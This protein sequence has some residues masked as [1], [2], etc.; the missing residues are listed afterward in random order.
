MKYLVMFLMMLAA[1]K[2]YAQAQDVVIADL[3]AEVEF[4]EGSFEEA[5]QLANELGKPL[6]VDAYA[7]WCGPCK[8]MN[9]HVFTDYKLAK[10]FN[11]NFVNYK[12][13]MEKGDGPAFAIEYKVVGYPTLL[14]LD[15]SGKVLQRNLGGMDVSALTALAQKVI[16]AWTAN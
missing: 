3:T 2:M 7:V 13:D 14:F 5:L 16:Q 9:K 10:L 8:W 1:T 15:G 4:F 12:Y 6:F 11:E